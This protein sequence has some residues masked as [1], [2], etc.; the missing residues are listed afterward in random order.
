MSSIQLTLKKLSESALFD[1]SKERLDLSIRRLCEEIQEKRIVLPVFQTYIRWTEEKVAA[2]FNYQLNGKAPMAPISVNVINKPEKVVEQI[3]FMTRE[4]L[5][6]DEIKGKISVADGQ[7]RLSANYNAYIN[8]PDYA[9]IV[10][11]IRKGKFIVNEPDSKPDSYQ[12]PAGI[13]YNKDQDVFRNYISKVAFLNKEEIRDVLSEVRRKHFAYTYVVNQATDLSRKAQ[14]EWFEVLNL[15]GSQVTETMVYLSD[16]LTKGVDFYT[17]YVYPFTE[18]L[19]ANDLGSLFPRKS[20]EVSIPLAALNSAYF[21]YTGLP[22]TSNSSPIPSD[23]KPIAIGKLN[24]EETRK[25]LDVTLDALDSVLAFIKQQAAVIKTPDRIDVITYLVGL[26]V[27]GEINIDSLSHVQMEFLIKW[28]NN[29]SF[30][31][32]SNSARREKFEQLIA[33]YKSL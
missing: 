16:M 19:E 6:G 5:E 4:V 21:K 22:K 33:D 23:A 26:F 10:L 13:L 20:A 32:N 17:Y 12:I 15:A 3:N 28:S 27:E 30:V 8:N 1:A 18:K 24:V 25:L 11:D 31:N 9:H 14:M 29:I 2:L 7:Q